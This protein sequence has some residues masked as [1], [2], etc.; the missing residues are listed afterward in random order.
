MPRNG[1]NFSLVLSLRAQR[2]LRTAVAPKGYSGLSSRV[3]KKPVFLRLA[4]NVHQRLLFGME[5]EQ[6]CSTEFLR[7][8]DVSIKKGSQR[9][10]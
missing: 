2:S 9:H 10:Y 7:G 5:N 8:I 1:Y 4:I 6:L 3:T